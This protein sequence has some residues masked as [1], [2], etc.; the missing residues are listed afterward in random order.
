M[1]DI[2]VQDVAT[3]GIVRTGIKCGASKKLNAKNF[4]LGPFTYQYW[5]IA[6]WNFAEGAE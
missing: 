2:V 6:N 5:N 4:A 3:I 1:N